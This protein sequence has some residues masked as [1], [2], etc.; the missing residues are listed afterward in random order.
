MN[1]ET[2]NRLCEQHGLPDEDAGKIKQLFNYS[3]MNA[4]EVRDYIVGA[5][6]GL[7]KLFDVWK[8]SRMSK[9]TLTTVGIAV[10]HAN[11]RRRTGEQLDLDIW[12]K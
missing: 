9:M 8:N 2:L 1:E 3:K 11:F 4:T 6:P 12:V 10:A 7:Q 5:R